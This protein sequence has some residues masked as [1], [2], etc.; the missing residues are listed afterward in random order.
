M[1]ITK[2][3]ADGS[4]SIALDGLILADSSTKPLPRLD[5]P[6]GTSLHDAWVMF[7]AFA[8]ANGLRVVPQMIFLNASGTTGTVVS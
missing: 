5:I 4:W 2:N 6:A 7:M 3:N 8:V 1:V